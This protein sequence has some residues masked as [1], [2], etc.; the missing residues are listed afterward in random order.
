MKAIFQLILAILI[1]STSVYSQSD[2][3]FPPM[4]SDDWESLSLEELAWCSD[5][6]QPL[7]DML[8]EEQTKAFLVLKDGKIVI[9]K[10]FDQFT[11][12]SLWV[13]NSAGKTLTAF[14]VGVA[15]E[16]GLLT[17][18]SATSDYLGAGWTS[19]SP[20]LENEIKVIHQLTMTSGLDYTVADAFCTDPAC[21]EYLN[22]PGSH[23][24][25]HNAPYSLLRNVLESATDRNL[26]LYTFQKLTNKIGMNGLWVPLGFNNIFVSNARSM[27]R[28]GLLMLN[29]GD[30]ENESLLND[31][32]YMAQ[33]TQTSQS[34]NPAYG[35]LWW[36]NGKDSFKIPGSDIVFSGPIVPEAPPSM[37]SALGANGQ[38]L[39]VIP[40]ENIIIVRMGNANNDALVAI[41]LINDIAAHLNELWCET[42]G[43]EEAQKTEFNVF[44][45]P[46]NGNSVVVTFDDTAFVSYE[47]FSPNGQ[48]ISNGTIQNHDR[49][50]I[51]DAAGTYVLSLQT[52]TGQ[53]RVLPILKK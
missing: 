25:Y 10:Y 17:L 31:K 45:N 5:A 37:Y 3:Y 48:L 8:E 26:N 36:L 40:D 32:A 51:P 28:F 12:D 42:N 4:D 41:T 35:Y 13:W 53:T 34:L 27:A 14:L 1:S 9:E 44:P 15:Q 30:W 39:S 21:L 33:L 43:I 19:L 24:Y 2:L 6:V 11:K 47:L 50:S 23:W 16:E 46:V 22:P 38:I 29:N 7:Y 18:E 49:I 52:K 20:D